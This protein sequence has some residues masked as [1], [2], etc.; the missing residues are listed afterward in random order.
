MTR[1]PHTARHTGWIFFALALGGFAIGT[2]E[3]AAMSLVPMMAA[4]L[5]VS[6]PEAGHAI[7]AYAAG[8]C[9]G[10][11]LIALFSARISR[12][13]MLIGMMLFYMLGNGLSAVAPTY[14]ALLAFRFLSGLPHGAYFGIAGLVAS[15]LVPPNRRAQAVARVVLG[16]TLATIGGVP[17]ANGIGQLVGWRWAFC[18]I[19]AIALATAL[20]IL[21]LAPADTPR[22]DASAMTELR[23]LGMRQVWLTL[24]IGAI[25]FGG[26]FC[27]YTYLASVMAAVT[28]APPALLPVALAVF[29]AGLTVGTVACAWAADRRMMPTI[30]G[31]LLL[32]VA[33][34]AAFSGSAHDMRTLLPV[35]FM[36][37]CGGGLA[38]VIQSRLLDIATGAEALAAALNQSAF[39]IANALGPWLGGLAIAAGWGW[40]SVGWVGCGLAA[41]GFAIWVVTVGDIRIAEKRTT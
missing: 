7:V 2:A 30:G 34:L 9:V 40:T 22:P 33:A 23:A 16:L 25:G 21:A 28:H 37:G 26:I 6:V 13:I 41:T 14:G 18:L 20:L 1:H 24:A 27:V 19:A 35:L 29:G 11:P 32:N 8:V 3:F 5:G 4:S 17:L 10:A 31:T 39:N 15:G 36:I 12:K 38:T